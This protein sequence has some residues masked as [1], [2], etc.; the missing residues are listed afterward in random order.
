LYEHRQQRPAP[1]RDDKILVAWNG[2]TISA[3]ARA[4]FAFDDP[5]YHQRA[6]RA[7][8]FILDHMRVGGRLQRSYKDE[9]AAGSGF[10]EDYAFFTAALLDLFAATAERR[11]LDHALALDQTLAGQFGDD[12]TGGFFMTAADHEALIA[13]EK[14]LLDGAMP[15]G[16]AVALMNLLR[17]SAVTSQPIFL[18]RAQ[19]GFMALSAVMERNPLAFGE[20]LLAYDDWLHPPGQLIVVT[21]VQGKTAAWVDR[22]R[23]TFLP[24]CLAV[25]AAESNVADL[26][27]SYPLF[28][29]KGVVD[30]R[31]TAYGCRQGA[32]SLPVNSENGLS[33]ILKSQGF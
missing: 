15:S 26:A 20:T 29:E 33:N 5:D 9:S 12:E 6:G 23:S 4:G 17:L 31:P 10:L 28:R 11:W 19:K 24:G 30:G 27:G 32:C 14:P 16:N 25:V 21:P 3:F 8:D 1:L 2:L 22:L 18:E 13:R 7:A